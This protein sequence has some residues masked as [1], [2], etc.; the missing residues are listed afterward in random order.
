MTAMCDNVTVCE[1]S[2]FL[3]YN[4]TPLRHYTSSGGILLSDIVHHRIIVQSSMVQY[5]QGQCDDVLA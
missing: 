4:I 3:H 5:G 1:V 2:T